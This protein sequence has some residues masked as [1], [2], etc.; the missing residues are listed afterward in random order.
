MDGLSDETKMDTQ[1]EICR[2][3]A[4]DCLESG[5][6]A[7][8]VQL[9]FHLTSIYDHSVFEAFSKV[10]LLDFLNKNYQVPQPCCIIAKLPR[11]F[12]SI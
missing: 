11:L 1:R 10:K 3:W 12:S 6:D 8:G 2:H 5:L 4:D 7:K 9:T